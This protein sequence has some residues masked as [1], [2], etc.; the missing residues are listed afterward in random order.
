MLSDLL[1]GNTFC[2]KKVY[3][4]LDNSWRHYRLNNLLGRRALKKAKITQ[5]REHITG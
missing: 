3:Q 4:M 1:W 2:L 5:G